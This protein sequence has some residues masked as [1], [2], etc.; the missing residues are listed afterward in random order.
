MTVGLFCKSFAPDLERVVNLVGS[1]EAFNA[2]NLA[3]T[4]AVPHRDM[5]IFQSKIPSWI[6]IVNE[7]DFMQREKNK[8]LSGW[9]DQQVSKLMFGVESP[10]DHFVI[11]DSDCEFIKPFHASDFL[12]NK[13]RIP[14]I[15]TT[16]YYRYTKDKEFI[17]NVALGNIIPQSMK[18]DTVNFFSND[19]FAMDKSMIGHADILSLKPSDVGRLINYAFGRRDNAGVF[20]MPTPVIWSKEVAVSFWRFLQERETSMSDIILYSPWEAVW[21]G[22]YALSRFRDRVDCREPIALHFISDDDIA[23]AKSK[24]VSRETMKTNFLAV[25]LAARHQ[26]EIAF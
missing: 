12:K 3:M 2:D 7:N 10:F 1:I 20:F 16:N 14:L 6:E 26:K 5:Q 11:L 23:Y 8:I 22:L 13:D 17:N 9:R 4:L 15:A 25:T 18:I 21:Y 24:G 19:F